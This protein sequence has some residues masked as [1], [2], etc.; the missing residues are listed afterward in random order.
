MLEERNSKVLPTST[1]FHFPRHP[2]YFIWPSWK[3]L[4]Y[5]S[6][7]ILG[8]DDPRAKDHSARKGNKIPILFSISLSYLL[9]WEHWFMDPWIRLTL[10]AWAF[11]V[12]LSTNASLLRTWALR[13]SYYISYCV[14]LEFV[15]RILQSYKWFLPAI[16]RFTPELRSHR[17]ELHSGSR[18]CY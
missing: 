16:L 10:I 17:P 18:S 1:F 8:F 4:Y 12:P 15:T 13:Y 6:E 9:R 7:G 14:S 5:L 2:E 11:R 3:D